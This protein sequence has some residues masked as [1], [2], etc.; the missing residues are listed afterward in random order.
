MTMKKILYFLVC[1]LLLASCE[2][3]FIDQNLGGDEWTSTDVRTV[4]YSLIDA[5]Y[6]AI[7]KDAANIHIA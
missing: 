2:N 3:Y 7:A 4:R 1:T 6:T 5:D